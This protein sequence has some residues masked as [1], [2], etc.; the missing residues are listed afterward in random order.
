M[1]QCES[2]IIKSLFYLVYGFPW[3]IKFFFYELFDICCLSKYLLE[4][5]LILRFTLTDIIG[6]L[7]SRIFNGG[8]AYSTKMCGYCMCFM[9]IYES[10][11]GI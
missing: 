5:A 3:F 1:V 11:D 9:M 10:V 6:F 2:E 7:N 4:R 8:V